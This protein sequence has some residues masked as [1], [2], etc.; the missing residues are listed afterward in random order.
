MVYNPPCHAVYKV[1]GT[2]L[3][4]QLSPSHVHTQYLINYFS[5]NLINLYN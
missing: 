3:L 2:L 5:S 4:L 1:V